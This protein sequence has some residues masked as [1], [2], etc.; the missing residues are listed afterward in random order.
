METVGAATWEHSLRSVKPGGSV[1]ISG[2]TSGY[3]APTELNRVF[4]LQLRVVGSTMGSRDELERLVQMCAVT[5]LR[6]LI[7]HT[8]P[9]EQAREAFST[10]AR[11]DVFGKIVLT[12]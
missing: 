5:G 6:P 8:V 9:M 10:L 3:R 12:R 4:F 11:G 1:V 2:A 7:D